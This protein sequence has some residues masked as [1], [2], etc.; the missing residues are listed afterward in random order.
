V[1]LVSVVLLF[2]LSVASG[3]ESASTSIS[4][5][6]AKIKVQSVGDVT[7]A[8]V[9]GVDGAKLELEE[10]VQVISPMIPSALYIKKH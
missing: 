5:S 7:F 2:R 6:G 1:T 10:V 8:D 3:A 9:M 4:G